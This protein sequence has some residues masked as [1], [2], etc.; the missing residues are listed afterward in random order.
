MGKPVWVTKSGNL[1]TIQE[2]TFYQLTM[3]A[4]DPDGTDVTYKVIAGNLPPGLVMYETGELQ[5]QP[6]ELYYIRGVPFD[7]KQD[8]TS[9]F[10]CRATSGTGQLTDRTFSITVTGEDPPEI[11]TPSQQ[12]ATVL[13]G[14]YI[15]IQ[16]EVIDL[17][18]EPV[19]WA[20]VAG[21][22]PKGVTLDTSTGLLSGYVYPE[23][24]LVI[25]NLEGWS[26]EA[27]WE[28]YP[29][30]F[31]TVGISKAYQFDVQ[32]TDGKTFDGARYSIFVI[33][34]DSLTG[35]DDSL[36]A[37]HGLIVTGDVT[38][39]H[40][41]VLL[42]PPT[43]LGIYTHDN[44]FAYKFE[45]LDF[46]DDEIS[47]SLLLAVNL[48]YDNEI[49]G[50][51]STLYD[52]ANF[53]LPPGLVLN[54]ETGWLYGQIPTQ[55]SGQRDYTFAVSVY[56]TN[57]TEYTSDLT[58]FNMT[59]VNDLKY[60]V[61]WVTARDLGSIESGTPSEK[62]VLATNPIGRNLQYS[63]V[64]D[65][66]VNTSLPQGLKL[67]PDGLIVGRPS[68]ELTSFDAGSTTFDRDV[69]DLGFIT[70]ELTMDRSFTFKV[71]ATDSSGELLSYRTFTLKVEPSSYQPYET[72]YLKSQSGIED[73]NTLLQLLDDT[74]LIPAVSLY[75]QSDPYFGKARDLRLM[76][77]S[78]ITA[79]S[80]D[81]YVTA[82]AT[83]H[84]RKLLRFGD[85]KT[86][87]ALNDDGSVAYE[88][89]Y[90]EVIDDLSFDDKTAP[91]S[92]NL[93]GKITKDTLVDTLK[94]SMDNELLTMDGSGD[95]IIYPNSLLNMRRILT[96]KLGLTLKEPLP[97]WM[98]SKQLDG[99]ILGWTPSAVIAYL[100]PGESNK[101]V[102]NLNRQSNVDLKLISFDL[103]RYI[104]DNNMSRNYDTTT[105]SYEDSF[106]TFFDKF[107]PPIF[108]PAG[109]AD[110]AV[111]FPFSSIDGLTQSYVED[112]L[113]G[114]DGIIDVY[115]GKRIIFVTQENY[116]GYIL[117]NDGWVRNLN[118][119]QDGTGWDESVHGWDHYEI[120]PGYIDALDGSTINQRSAIWLITRDSFGLFRLTVDTLIEDGETVQV[121]YG[122]KYGG[123]ILRYGPIPLFFQ[124]ETVPKYSKFQAVD[125]T[126]ETTFDNNKTKFINS[127]T[128]YQDPDAGDKYL[129]FPR[130][131][132]WV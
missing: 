18:N 22:L 61:Q 83:N 116:P 43:D 92:I 42:T 39:K 76:L 58:F 13:S 53:Q 67:N 26:S 119:W 41:P 30:D 121:R 45:G 89:V 16:L 69:R 50:F 82:M 40:R 110:F 113:Q 107:L 28:A 62:Y 49:N 25:A 60:V 1:G 38:D 99:R 8:V 29:W 64:F 37:D 104:L 91:P 44:Y 120:I 10:C 46:D 54:T 31:N 129:E 32:A 98:T 123:F 7:V 131:N 81:E 106:Q 55:I 12:L 77:L 105:D 102:F 19:S 87:R 97:R 6:K 94:V 100:K 51:A 127:I 115:E 93:S 34:H 128:V 57:Y 112:V 33:A 68:F 125:F 24:P 90:I 4:Y 117:E 63:L 3:E 122:V 71:K 126:V 84:Y 66:D 101:V 11:I 59:I 96:S 85:Y 21:E 72:L 48:G 70:E 2:Q 23:T 132:I 35:D 111:D 124:G 130:E 47:F 14:D 17:D 9:T 114:L 20:V 108:D 5:G 27:A 79:S 118:S 73:R 80:A 75:R 95:K 15:S 74:D 65:D 36:L 52:P 86:A 109:T 103:D 78:G 88:V 56:K